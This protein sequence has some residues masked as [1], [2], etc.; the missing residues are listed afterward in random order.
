MSPIENLDS[1]SQPI[2]SNWYLLTVRSKKREV[3]LKHLNFAIAKNQ[4]EELILEIK[5]PQDSVYEDMVLL[6]L[7]N[8]QTVTPY[9]KKVE[10]F[11]NIERKPLQS[12]QVNRML[13][14]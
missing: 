5:I 2:S 10:C 8:F 12:A 11:Q 6:H 4:L 3:F 9:L 1:S 13:S 14:K 7:S